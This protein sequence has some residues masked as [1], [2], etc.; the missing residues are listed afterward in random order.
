VLGFRAG[1]EDVGGDAQGERE[2]F[3]FAED[4]LDGLVLGAPI[5]P[6]FELGLLGGGWLGVGVGEEPGAVA[7]EGAQEEEFG[8]AAGVGV[9]AEAGGGLVEERS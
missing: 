2:E 9:V 8:V 1:D 6:P 3:L 5:E 7:L 4:V